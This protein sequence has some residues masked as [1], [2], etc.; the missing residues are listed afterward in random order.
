L[1]DRSQHHTPPRVDFGSERVSPEEK[2]RRVAGVFNAVA[3]QYDLMNDLMSL[4]T[5]RVLKRIS[6]E[7]SGVR[8]GHRVL[9][10][11]GGTGDL[12]SLYASAVGRAGHVVLA[13]IN[14]AM[15]TVGRDRL[16]D[17]GITNVGY[18]QADAEALPFPDG[19][20]DCVSI[21]FGL[22]NV[23][24]QDRALAEMQRVLRPGGRLVVLEFS[25]PTNPLLE[26][27]YA[28]F[29]AFWP[30]VGRLITGEAAP[31]RYL[32]ESIRNHPHQKALKQMIGDAGF[33]GVE[34][35][36]LLGGIVAIHHARKPL[37][38]PASPEPRP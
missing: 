33:E 26:T 13:D 25:R 15:I 21:G 24:H 8:P 17:R 18:C 5:H 27:A 6:I 16:L 36:N 7:R 22:R 2:T 14:G 3:D 37:D 12:T 20:F 32:V 11:A 30:P 23:T 1:T 4:G 34:Y 19:H 29:Q 31:Y 38:V 35:D 10:L 9:D 28:G